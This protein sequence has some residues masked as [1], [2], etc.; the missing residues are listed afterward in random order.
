[1]AG[2]EGSVLFIMHKIRSFVQQR[3]PAKD[4]MNCPVCP[5]NN[6]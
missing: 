2:K 5:S 3:A 4:C 6:I 1:M